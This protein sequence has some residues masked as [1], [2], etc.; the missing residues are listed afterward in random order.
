MPTIHL[1]LLKDQHVSNCSCCSPK[2]KKNEYIVCG[3]G[4]YR[5]YEGRKGS[6]DKSMMYD[7]DGRG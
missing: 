7:D 1:N 4:G 6:S 5:K 2:E 3:V